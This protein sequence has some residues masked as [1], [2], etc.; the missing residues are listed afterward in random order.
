MADI[1][2]T[3]R[4]SA[5]MSL[6]KSKNTKPEICVRKY[7][8]AKGLRYRLH[9][10]SLPGSPDLVLKKYNSVVFVQGC[11][12]H[13][14]YPGCR[15]GHIPK[16]NK[17]YWIKKINRN[18]ERDQE[19]IEALKR[20]GWKVFVIW[21]CELKKSKRSSTLENIIAIITNSSDQV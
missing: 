17:E 18:Q 10:K 5:L 21:E 4:R 20:L 11:F 12:W 6:I 2:T 14:H 7:F 16:T 1:M 13:H 3:E 19:N 9:D 15:S 8:H